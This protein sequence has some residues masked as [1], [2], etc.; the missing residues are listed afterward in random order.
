[1]LRDLRI[2]NFAII[3]DLSLPFDYGLNIITGDTGAG[4][5]ILVGALGLVLGGRGSP[6][7]IRTGAEQA[8][9][10]ACFNLSTLPLQAE[11]IRDMGLEI[12]DGELIIH[13]TL[14]RTG[15]ARVTINGDPATVSLLSRIGESL[16][17]IHGQHEHHSLL[18]RELH[19]DL[20]DAFG[21]TEKLLSQ[22]HQT[23]S[24]LIQIK[25][26]R[27][28]IEDEER[29]RE[30]RIDFLQYQIREINELDPR[31]G[32]EKELT[33][34]RDILRNAERIST[35]AHESYAIL[36]E[37]EESLT[38]LLGH[39]LSRLNELAALD[40]RTEALSRDGEDLKYRLEDMAHTLRDHASHTE[41][42][43]ERLTAIEDRLD[44][45][46]KLKRKY[47]ETIDAI[48]GFQQKA[49]EELARLMRSEENRS[50][51]NKEYE[52]TLSRAGNQAQELSRTRT[53]AARDMEKELEGG[54]ADL[55]MSGTRFVV[56]METHPGLP[57]Y[58][59]DKKGRA[60][61]PKGVDRIEFL[62]SPNV[63]EEPKPLIRIASGGEL[64]R[65]M[66]AIK[67]VLAGVDQVGTLIF[68]EVDSGIGGGVA[69][70]LGKRLRFVAGGRQVICVTHLPQVASQGEAHH[71]IFKKVEDGR[72]VVS[73]HRLKGK[74][75]VQEIARMLGGVEVT[76]TTIRH[77]R[78]MLKLSG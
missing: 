14:N 5:S 2:Q 53:I 50:R 60:L 69:E 20:L 57:E 30:Q 13:R 34:E 28:R 16:V 72:T 56:Q 6:D 49:E 74:E 12:P 33:E 63:G 58:P 43:P 17:D 41:P 19:I 65:I 27:Q 26:E 76:Q 59:A 25:E 48:L 10:T 35:L 64:S 73:A 7:M 39:V 68:D 70:I 4:K 45:L 3:E 23:Y 15:K 9:I 51:L 29:D 24:Q 1:M 40:A 75:R 78:E 47:G 32:E 46:Q 21:R 42:D 31:P 44:R 54:L 8:R 11:R 37:S 71:H 61:A 62:V 66:L 36:Y 77:A 52:E 22:Y 18:N 38:D 67:S 55:S